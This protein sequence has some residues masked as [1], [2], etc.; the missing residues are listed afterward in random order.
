MDNGRLHLQYTCD[1]SLLDTGADREKKC[2]FTVCIFTKTS[3]F[4]YTY[5]HIQIHTL[6]STGAGCLFGLKT[7]FFSLAFCCNSWIDNMGLWSPCRTI[8][9]FLERFDKV[10]SLWQGKEAS[11]RKR[12]M[13]LMKMHCV[14]MSEQVKILVNH[15]LCTEKL[16]IPKSENRANLLSQVLVMLTAVT[17]PNC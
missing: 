9:R 7:A 14:E 1:L 6:N 3:A 17:A 8:R 11:L 2:S 10:V 12:K 16:Q 4:P 13:T 5:T 15:F